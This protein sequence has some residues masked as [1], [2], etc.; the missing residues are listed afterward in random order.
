MQQGTRHCHVRRKALQSVRDVAKAACW[1][2]KVSRVGD[3]REESF[4]DGMNAKAGAG[5]KK[6]FHDGMNAKA[7]EA[8]K[9][10]FHDGMN[11]KAAEAAKKS[12]HAGMNAKLQR[13]EAAPC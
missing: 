1:M 9:K 13:Q 10:A 11:A 8:A 5:A 3:R 6:S 2:I 12:F 4:H 7:A